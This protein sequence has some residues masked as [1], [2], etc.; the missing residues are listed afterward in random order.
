MTMWWT[1]AVA[2]TAAA[3]AFI[4]GASVGGRSHD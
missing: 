3:A 4:L 2:L 1:L